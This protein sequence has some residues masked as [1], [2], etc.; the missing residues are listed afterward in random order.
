VAEVAV[1]VANEG[2]VEMESD[3]LRKGA[4]LNCEPLELLPLGRL[5]PSPEKKED[6]PPVALG[7]GI[8]DEGD[9]DKAE[10]AV[11][12]EELEEAKEEDEELEEAEAEADAAA[13]A[14]RLV[15]MGRLVSLARI[16]GEACVPSSSSESPNGLEEL[17]S[18]GPASCGSSSSNGFAGDDA[19]IL[20]TPSPSSSPK[21]FPTRRP[22]MLS[23]IFLKG[24]GFL[25]V[26][27]RKM[28]F[29]F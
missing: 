25:F 23:T 13:V 14:A 9:G 11:D 18:A 22:A 5:A 3:V 16:A 4:E 8:A 7:L 24:K 21:G 28:L 2:D 27:A 19:G 17:A 20:T 10:V 15:A 12:E 29:F 1:V 6:K 26:S